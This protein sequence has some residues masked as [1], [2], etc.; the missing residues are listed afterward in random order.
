M[1]RKNKK[2][3]VRNIS[4]EENLRGDGGKQLS[5]VGREEE[6]TWTWTWTRPR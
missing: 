6:A 1:R 2:I 4:R 5:G 3:F